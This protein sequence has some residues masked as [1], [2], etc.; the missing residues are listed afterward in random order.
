MAGALHDGVAVTLC[1]QALVLPPMSAKAARQHWDRIKAMQSGE[2]GLPDQLELTIDL[3][4]AC[5]L[6]NHPELSREMVEEH[7]DVGNYDELGAMCFGRGAWLRWVEVQAQ[8]AGNVLPPPATLG[9]GGTGASSTPASPPPPAGAS[10][11]ST[12]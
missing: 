2:L 12:S 4:H 10:A 8:L 7:V 6:R 5:L 1:G 3:V 9:A 11:T